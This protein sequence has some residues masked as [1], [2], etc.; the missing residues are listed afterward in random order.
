[1]TAGE[2][3]TVEDRIVLE[4]RFGDVAAAIVLR[5]YEGVDAPL[6]GT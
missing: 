4:I 3:Y 5:A 2:I 6:T 1:V